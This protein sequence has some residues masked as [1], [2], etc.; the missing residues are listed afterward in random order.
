MP[1]KTPTVWILLCN[2]LWSC[3]QDL[4]FRHIV[5]AKTCGRLRWSTIPFS[6]SRAPSCQTKG[7][8]LTIKLFTKVYFV[9]EYDRRNGSNQ[10]VYLGRCL[11][12]PVMQNWVITEAPHLHINQLTWVII[13]HSFLQVPFHFE[14]QVPLLWPDRVPDPVWN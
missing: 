10:L 6:G 12:K 2:V 9:T 11:V 5:P 8:F 7:R 1:N 4:I 14:L 13:A 3:V